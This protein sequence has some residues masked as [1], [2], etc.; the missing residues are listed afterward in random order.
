MT[1]NTGSIVGGPGVEGLFAHLLDT[2]WRGV[3]F[4]VSH[5]TTEVR[6]DLVV[7][8]FA[9]RDG[10]HVESTGRHPIQMS[11]TIPFIVG[12][13]AGPNESWK[14]VPLYPTQWRA[15]F[16]ACCDNTSGPLQHPELGLLTCKVERCHTVWS[17][18]RRGGVD[19][20]ASWLESD[21][22]GGDL[23]AALATPSPLAGLTA[24][25]AAI[26]ADLAAMASTVTG[27]PTPYT[28]P[29]SLSAMVSQITAIA[30]SVT[31]LQQG[32]AGSVASVVYQA[33]RVQASL[34]A[35]SNSLNWPLQLACSQTI[36]SANNA[37]A[38]A[39]AGPPVQVYT[40]TADATIGA[41]ATAI[42][43]DITSLL[44]LNPALAASP[45]VPRG[46]Q[47]RYIKAG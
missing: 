27:M 2:T 29:F 16:L 41:L 35:A 36:E 45:V 40:T 44:A 30:G 5:Y 3:S 38:A 19:V 9:D 10:G 20:D 31:A 43:S 17:A 47:V 11:A 21:D 6:Q 23:T 37:L 25:A 42:P 18:E 7:Q 34:D 24:S 4:P 8:K 28:P 39:P 12:I 15:F 13:N 46:T 33:Q 22:T 26:D 1:S 14:S 32:I